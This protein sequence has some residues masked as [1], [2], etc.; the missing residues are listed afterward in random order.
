MWEIDV[1]LMWRYIGTLG[2]VTH[3]AQ[4]TMIDN[5]PIGFFRDTIELHGLGFIDGIEKSREC[6]TEIEAAATAVA[7]IENPLQFAKKLR[8]L[9]EI[10]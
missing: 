9:V 1:P 4:I 5:A 2:H 10:T 8:F 6:V 7:Y 3:V